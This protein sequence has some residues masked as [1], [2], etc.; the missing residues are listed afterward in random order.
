MLQYFYFECIKKNK[1]RGESEKALTA[2]YKI[3]QGRLKTDLF[4][5]YKLY[6]Y[7]F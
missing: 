7:P 2:F 6:C 4:F 1:P 3:L 5:K